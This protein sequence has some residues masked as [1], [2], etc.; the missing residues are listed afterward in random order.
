MP[1]LSPSGLPFSSRSSHRIGRPSRRAQSSCGPSCTDPVS[2]SGIAAT[3]LHDRAVVRLPSGRVS[4]WC[5]P[6]VTHQARRVLEPLYLA[7]LA[8]DEQRGEEGDP[9]YRHQ[10][11]GILVAPRL[12][13]YRPGRLVY[14]SVQAV[15]EPQIALDPRVVQRPNLLH[16]SFRERAHVY[17]DVVHE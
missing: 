11:L 17:R 16:E 4:R 10:E 14:L 9:R 6:G 13:A 7:Y 1:R 3:R 12:L 5:Q 15:Y 2:I 8:D